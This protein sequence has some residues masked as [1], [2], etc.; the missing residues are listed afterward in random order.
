[1]KSDATGLISFDEAF[2]IV[3]SRAE[4][5][6]RPFEPCV[7]TQALG[8]TLAEDIFTDLDLPLADN[9]AMDGY[10]FR[11]CDLPLRNSGRPELPISGSCFA[12]VRPP[13]LTLGSACYIT[14]G[15][16]V[17][18]GADTVVKIEDVTV[19]EAGDSIR[20][21]R[22]PSQG[23]FVRRKGQD[24]AAGRKVASRGELI[25]PYLIGLLAS[26]GKSAVKTVKLPVVAIITSGD[27]LAMTWQKP[28]PWQVRSSNSFVLAA[29]AN[30]AGALP[31]DLGISSDSPDHAVSLIRRAAEL[32]DI[33]VTSGGISMGDKDP[34]KEAVRIIPVTQLVHGVALKPGKPFFFGM[35]GEKPFFGLPGNQAASAITF[36]LFVRPFIAAMLGRS[37]P[38]YQTLSLPLKTPI[39]NN[40]DRDNFVRSRIVTHEGSTM[41]EPLAKQE[42]HMFS[43]LIGFTH[44]I[45][46]RAGTGTIKALTPVEGISIGYCGY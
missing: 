45:R 39:E 28:Q 3:V 11:Y 42:S 29:Q 10:G 14:T 4:S 22:V 20:F 44:L 36:E 6:D 8:R 9:S 37:A 34:I 43:S 2:D 27:E 30:R 25:S 19:S 16:L 32:A 17:P 15:G 31:V 41:F 1:M 33:I 26:T 23:S 12:G 46:H 24:L 38:F 5:V 21:E 35:L 7:I 13:E 40:T 18:P